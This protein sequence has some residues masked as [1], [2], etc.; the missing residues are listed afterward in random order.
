MGSLL[1]RNL[2]RWLK[3]VAGGIL[4]EA[5]VSSENHVEVVVFILFPK[6]EVHFFRCKE[7]IRAAVKT[8]AFGFYEPPLQ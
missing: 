3:D 8:A 4:E 1:K 5:R 7:W 6:P 2:T